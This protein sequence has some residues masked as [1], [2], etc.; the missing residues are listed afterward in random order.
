MN[1]IK[2]YIYV[3]AGVVLLMLFGYLYYLNDRLESTKAKLELANQ[4][5]SSLNHYIDKTNQQ[6][7][8][9]QQLDKDY[10][11]KLSH[12]QT[13][14][15][16]L[17]DS[18]A[19]GT[20]RLYVKTNCPMSANTATTSKPD[21]TSRAELDRE[22]GQRIIRIAQDGDHAIMQLN[23]LKKYVNEVCLKM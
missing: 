11:E 16:K 17:R 21:A 12:A 23:A 10:Q 4:N 9:I 2:N 20:K 15:D 3:A 7:R 6:L 13:E 5:I 1:A 22:T 18:I 8:T 14:N 19:N